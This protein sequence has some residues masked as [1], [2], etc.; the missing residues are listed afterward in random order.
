ME[1]VAIGSARE[2]GT[3]V[4]GAG[5]AGLALGYQLSRR[6][7]SFVILEANSRIGDSWRRRWDSLRL[8]TPARYDGLPGLPFPARPDYFPTKDEMADYLEAYAARFALPVET[9]TRVQKIRRVD[10]GYLVE[11]AEQTY[12]ARDVVVAMSNYQ[13]PHVPDFAR[14]IDDDILQIHSS[15]YCNPDQLRPGPVL[16]VGAGNSGS[17]LARELA[18]TRPTALAGAGTGQLPFRIESRLAHAIFIPL[19]L[20]LLFHRVLTVNT[21]VGRR[22]RRKVVN[23]GG[24]W[25]RVK[26]SDLARAGVERLPRVTGAKL[27][28]PLLADGSTRRPANIV[29]CTGFRPDLSWLDLPIEMAGHEPRHVGGSVPGLPGFY[30]VGLHFQH[31]LSSAM[32]QGVGRDA[33]RIAQRIARSHGTGQRQAIRITPNSAHEVS[34]QAAER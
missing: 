17:E 18:R 2:I 12:R 10:D 16:I 21:P 8:F 4:V 24:P 30:F 26:E 9:G 20:K 7:V 15:A 1:A 23:R 3:V 27:G 34:P 25:I 5:Q 28:L 13:R 31:A 22:V 14:E 33:A 11:T 6:G 29:W 19:V 32:I